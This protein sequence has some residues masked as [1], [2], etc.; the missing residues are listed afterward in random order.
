MLDTAGLHLR[1]VST[2]PSTAS[3]L[4]HRLRVCALGVMRLESQVATYKLL[5]IGHRFTKTRKSRNIRVGVCR[6]VSR[7]SERLK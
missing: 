1:G 3:T 4:K 5:Q 7:V 6:S 2:E